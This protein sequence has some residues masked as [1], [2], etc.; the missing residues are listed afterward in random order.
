MREKRQCSPCSAI[1][2]ADRF[3][4]VLGIVRD[5]AQIH[6]FRAEIHRSQFDVRFLEESVRIQR[7][8]E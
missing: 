3:R 5:P 7:D 1:R 4:N 8:F 6:A 2:L